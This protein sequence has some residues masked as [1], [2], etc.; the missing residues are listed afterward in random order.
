[1]SHPTAIVFPATR[2]VDSRRL[3]VRNP[4]K[5]TFAVKIPTSS[6]RLEVTPTCAIIEAGRSQHFRVTLSEPKMI[7]GTEGCYLVVMCRPVGTLPSEAYEVWFETPYGRDTEVARKISVVKSLGYCA[8]ETIMDLPGQ[9]SGV[10]G[11]WSPTTALDDSDTLTARNVESDTFTAPVIDEV[12]TANDSL[13]S[14]GMEAAGDIF[15]DS[16]DTLK[17]VAVPKYGWIRKFVD[18]AFPQATDN[19]ETTAFPCGSS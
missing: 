3:V 4:T 9:A 7:L 1:M 14:N 6:D 16:P 10:F 17:N 19:I 8:F 12:D 11:Y 2:S 18:R 15:Q 5:E 13:N